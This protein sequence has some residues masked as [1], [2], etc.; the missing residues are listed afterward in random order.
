MKASSEDLQKVLELTKLLNSSRDV[1]YILDEMM[2]KTLDIIK[3]ADIAVIFLYNPE[4]DEL[5][6]ATSVGFGDITFTLK[7]NES[8][9]GS[10]FVKQK[11][12]FL[13]SQKEMNEAMKTLAS[14]TKKTLDQ[15][16]ISPVDTIQSSISCPL[17]HDNECIGVFVL[18]NFETKPAMTESDVYLAELI[19]LNATIAIINASN[20]KRMLQE[21]DRYAY[22]T[23]LHNKFTTMVLEGKSVQGIID[24]VA[25]MRDKDVIVF[26]T[27]YKITHHSHD[28]DFD[29]PSVEAAHK[30]TIKSLS[31]TKHSKFYDA[32][33][34]F[35]IFYNPI[36]VNDILFGWVALVS[37]DDHFPEIE[38][39]TI[40]KCSTIIA[41]E[42]LKSEELLSMEHSLK[43][44]FLENLMSGQSTEIIEK[45]SK[46]YGYDSSHPHKMI[47]MKCHSLDIDEPFVAN[48]RYLYKKIRA[49]NQSLFENSITLQ[50]RNYIITIY[51]SIQTITRKDLESLMDDYRQQTEF[52]STMTH[53]SFYVAVVVSA[54]IA[55]NQEFKSAYEQT[56][57]IFNLAI[58]QNQSFVHYYFEDL[59]IK[60][61]LLANSSE[62]LEQFVNSALRPL[63]EYSN[64]SKLELFHTLKVYIQSGGNW[65]ATKNTLHIHGNTLTYRLNR[66]KKILDYDINDY[67]PSLRLKIAFEIIELHPE[68]SIK[69]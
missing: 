3:S 29:L 17:I 45:F 15:V 4:T 52:I 65:T 9:T 53:K 36:R 23:F 44:D 56:M 21:K 14:A 39:I 16:C 24:E 50:K 22:S 25:D 12:L 48:L 7:P 62:D 27:Y 47:I 10:T 26:D 55:T 60:R 18:D 57:K 49:L 20:Y 30:K 41:L 59:E 2:H 31:P 34:D 61:F 58:C 35:W 69:A 8:I 51:D 5:K 6:S 64:A 28:Q 40:D 37:R 1:K 68:Y 38:Q 67:Y 32:L 11:T 63:K 46:R 19:S 13:K 33:N 42:I 66:L 43:G 54:E